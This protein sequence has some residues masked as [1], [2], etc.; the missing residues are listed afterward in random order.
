MEVGRKGTDRLQG[1]GGRGVDPIYVGRVS[2]Q[3]VCTGQCVWVTTS[4]RNK[5]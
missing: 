3:T 2:G 1:D 5:I 4:K